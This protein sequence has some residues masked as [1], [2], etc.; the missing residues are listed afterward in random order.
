MAA[1][2]RRTES[3]RRRRN[4]DIQIEGNTVRKAAPE[5]YIPDQEE[6]SPAR[7]ARRRRQK[8]RQMSPAFVLFLS[9]ASMLVLAACIGYLQVQASINSRMAAIE[10]LEAQLED[11][12]DVNEASRSRIAAASDINQ[13]Y[14]TATE[15]LG[16]VYPDDSQ[17]IYYDQTEREYVQQYES[18]PKE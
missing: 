16:M 3:D 17:V 18:I 9:L 4:W 11:M 6:L 1:Y 5:I 10:E 7:K 15:E 13:I 2:G 12:K 14:K 8:A